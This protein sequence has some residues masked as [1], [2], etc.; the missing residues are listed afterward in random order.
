LVLIPGCFISVVFNINYLQ[1]F[2]QRRQ[3][4]PQQRAS[5]RLQVQRQRGLEA[6]ARVRHHHGQKDILRAVRFGSDDESLA[7]RSE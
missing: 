7:R 1:A 6:P 3:Q 4:G 2:F 5:C